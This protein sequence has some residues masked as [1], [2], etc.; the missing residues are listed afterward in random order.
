MRSLLKVKISAGIMVVVVIAIFP[1]STARSEATN[2]QVGELAITFPQNTDWQMIKA[3][4]NELILKIMSF[5]PV[6]R[7]YE[8]ITHELIRVSCC[9]STE[10]GSNKRTQYLSIGKAQLINTIGLLTQE[11]LREGFEIGEG[12]SFIKV[13]GVDAYKF[14]LI[15]HKISPQQWLRGEHTKYACH[16]L[17]WKKK[18]LVS[19]HLLQ[20]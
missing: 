9:P 18:E 3:G 17:L 2:Y 12:S 13:A 8:F 20:F 7:R 14:E 4:K 6:V 10:A 11:F 19:Y 16:I 1:V 5:E 15:K